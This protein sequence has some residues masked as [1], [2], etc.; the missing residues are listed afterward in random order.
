MKAIMHRLVKLESRDFDA[1]TG[2]SESELLPLEVCGTSMEPSI[3]KGARIW[4]KP[5][6]DAPLFVG[7]VITYLGSDGSLITHRIVESIGGSHGTAFRVQGDFQS[8][9]DIVKRSEIAYKV[10][11]VSNRSFTYD[12]D[13]RFGKWTAKKVIGN[14]RYWKMLQQLILRLYRYR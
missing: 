10:I 11:R 4:V 2:T 8:F 9:C 6:D 1:E 13:S 7:D 5:V 14:S 12:T 3:R